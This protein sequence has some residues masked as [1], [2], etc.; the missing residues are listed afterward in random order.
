MVLHMASDALDLPKERRSEH[1]ILSAG[2]ELSV[3]LHARGEG[4]G[5]GRATVSACLNQARK[6]TGWVA[7][8]D[9]RCRQKQTANVGRTW[10]TPARHAVRLRFGRPRQS[11]NRPFESVCGAASRGVHTHTS[12]TEP[13]CNSTLDLWGSFASPLRRDDPGKR[14][15]ARVSH[16]DLIGKQRLWNFHARPSGGSG[17]RV[18]HHSARISRQH[19]FFFGSI[20]FLFGDGACSHS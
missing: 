14:L 17:G 1:M 2:A 5:G 3:N 11:A 20:I 13:K 7:C 10:N 16:T 18:R 4:G 9:D 6:N 8:S 19:F 12:P 15:R